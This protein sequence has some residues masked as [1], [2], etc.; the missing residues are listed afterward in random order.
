M[1]WKSQENNLKKRK[2]KSHDS[3]SRL[4]HLKIGAS[5]Y[6]LTFFV[7][8]F[9]FGCS[10]LHA[11]LFRCSRTLVSA[12]LLYFITQSTLSWPI[13]RC[14]FHLMNRVNASAPVLYP[15]TCVHYASHFASNFHGTFQALYEILQFTKFNITTQLISS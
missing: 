2:L 14:A 8:A 5:H 15:A 4:R 11:L 1:E 3:Y 9:W 7:S 13:G 10:L 12:L 6:I